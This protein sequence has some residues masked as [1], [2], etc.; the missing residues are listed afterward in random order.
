[1]EKLHLNKP[2][3]F[4]GS[5]NIFTLIDNKI[6]NEKTEYFINNIAKLCNIH[7]IKTD[8]LIV[9]NNSEVALFSASF[10]NPDGTTGMMCGNA[11]RCVIYY[12]SKTYNINQQDMLEFIINDKTYFGSYCPFVDKVSIALNLPDKFER[13]KIAV[14]NI[15]YDGIFVDGDTPHFIIEVNDVN[16]IDIKKIGKAIRNHEAF[17]PNGTNVNFYQKI[18]ENTIKLRTFERGVEDETGACGTGAVATTVAF[19]SQYKLF[20]K[21]VVI[22]KSESKLYVEYSK[23]NKIEKIILSGNVKEII[24]KN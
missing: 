10:F 3:I 1:M 13:K 4:S 22:P 11:G 18:N 12:Y 23:I 15:D 24:S 14:D 17:S 9:V 5:G 16:E 21:L 20:D 2:R 19:C 7:D 6:K 8:G